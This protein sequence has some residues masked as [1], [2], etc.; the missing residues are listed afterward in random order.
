[1][2]LLNLNCLFFLLIA[3]ITSSCTT[4]RGYF[5]IGNPTVLSNDKTRLS[6]SNQHREVIDTKRLESIDPFTINQGYFLTSSLEKKGRVHFRP[7]LTSTPDDQKSPAEPV[8]PSKLPPGI[9]VS[10]ATSIITISAPEKFSGLVID[11]FSNLESYSAHKINTSEKFDPNMMGLEE[12]D[13]IF[14]IKFDLWV[15]PVRQSYL[16]YIWRWIPEVLSEH[17][18]RNYT[19]DYH[20]EINFKL[21]KVCAEPENE[22]VQNSQLKNEG[23]Q[24]DTAKVI[25]VQPANE[26]INSFDMSLL[27]DTS[28]FSMIGSWLSIAAGIDLSERHREQLAQQRKDPILRGL[29]NSE[30]VFRFLI[31]PRIHVEQRTFRIPFLMSRYSIER[32]LESGPYSVSAYILVKNNKK[33]TELPITICGNYKLLGSAA[34]SDVEDNDPIY[35][36]NRRD[37]QNKSESLCF[38]KQKIFL[39]RT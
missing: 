19:K 34:R 33:L 22:A 31:S 20:A 7:I 8:D 23:K 4:N 6:L 14:K 9:P 1:M 32:G 15:E 24:C 30:T 11:G 5:G 35:P 39:K 29:I 27:Q 28:Q 21:G 2:K 3:T 36:I 18:F 12:N 13:E 10:D 17:G 16:S 38:E 37:S 26:G 25:L